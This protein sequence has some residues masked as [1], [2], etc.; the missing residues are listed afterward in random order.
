MYQTF[1]VEVYRGHLIMKCC[2]K[3]VLL[4]TG[5][6]WTLGSGETLE[7]MGKTVYCEKGGQM[8]NIDSVRQ[9][10]GRDI[11]VL[12]GMNVLDGM[13]MLVDLTADEVTFS[14][15]PLTLENAVTIFLERPNNF[16]TIRAEVS[17]M[18]V[19]LVVDTG[20]QL[21]Y[22]NGQYIAGLD[23]IGTHKDFHPLMGHYEVPIYGMPVNIA[24]RDLDVVWGEATPGVSALISPIG[25]DGVLGYDLFKQGKV[26]FDFITNTLQF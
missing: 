12:M 5:S 15:E 4:D 8:Y 18:P 2:G 11:D 1:E 9:L 3:D 25:A 22:L 20:A 19:N 26:M 14:D 16:V 10:L 17:G 7:F 23:P 6:P 13:C 21:S 24:G